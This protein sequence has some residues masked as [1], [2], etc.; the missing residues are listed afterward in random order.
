MGLLA[1]LFVDHFPVAN[2]RR[3]RERGTKAV[4]H[5]FPQIFTECLGRARHGPRRRESPISLPRGADTLVGI[6]RQ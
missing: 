1:F 2:G 4:I 6:E 5:S 3:E